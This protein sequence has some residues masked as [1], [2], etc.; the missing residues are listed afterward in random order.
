MLNLY[1]N[2]KHAR[3]MDRQGTAQILAAVDDEWRQQALRWYLEEL[4]IQIN[5]YVRSTGAGNKLKLGFNQTKYYCLLGCERVTSQTAAAF[6]GNLLLYP[7]DNL[8]SHSLQP[9]P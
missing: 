4:C 6:W 3:I 9:E 8:V 7:A 5:T 2:P 1:L